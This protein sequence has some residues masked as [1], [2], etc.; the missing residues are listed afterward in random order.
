MS[1]NLVVILSIIL[2][3]FA[4]SLGFISTTSATVFVKQ[5]NGS[6]MVKF[7]KKGNVGGC[8]EISFGG[9]T[10]INTDDWPLKWT[11]ILMIKGTWDMP[12]YMQERCFSIPTVAKSGTRTTRPIKDSNGKEIG[13]VPIGALCAIHRNRKLGKE[14]YRGYHYVTY[15]GVTGETI[16]WRE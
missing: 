3:L 9:S 16:C 15:K 7:D 11:P 14:F 1:K 2:S 13:R 4:M 5:H 8:F 6:P 10:R 12:T